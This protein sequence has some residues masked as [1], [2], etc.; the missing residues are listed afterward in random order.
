[1][2]K[3]KMCGLRRREDIEYANILLPDY[4]GYVFAQSSKRYIVPEKATELTGFLDERIVSVGVFVDSGFDEIY[5]IV[6][7]G[8]VKAVQLHGNENEAYAPF[9]PNH[10]G[11][12]SPPTYYRGC[13]HVVSRG[14][15]L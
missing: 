3:I 7:A 1:M 9:T 10:S 5:G 8:A 12:R 15:L 4:I 6:S 14:F 13:W 11:Q 2:T